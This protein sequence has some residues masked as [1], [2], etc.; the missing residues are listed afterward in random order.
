MNILILRCQRSFSNFG[1]FEFG[2][3]K[4][5]T[6]HHSGKN[7][8]QKLAL[9]PPSP[10]IYHTL[11]NYTMPLDTVHICKQLTEHKSKTRHRQTCCFMWEYC[12][13]KN[14]LCQSEA[15]EGHQLSL[16]GAL[17]CVLYKVFPTILL[18]NFRY[19]M[20]LRLW[21]TADQVCVCHKYHKIHELASAQIFIV[22]GYKTKHASGI[23]NYF[24]ACRN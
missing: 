4:P 24:L 22:G 18:A 16:I 1:P 15:M 10:C 23:N 8:E 12:Q 7:V 5:K 19:R 9:F 2:F 11:L 14:T 20:E 21:R 6:Y 13:V 17:I 3:W